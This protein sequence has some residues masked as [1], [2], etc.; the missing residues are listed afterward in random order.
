MSSSETS[1]NWSK[2]STSEKPHDELS[3]SK[4][5]QLADDPNVEINLDTDGNGI[6]ININGTTL[7]ATKNSCNITIGNF[8]ITL[9]DKKKKDISTIADLLNVNV[10]EVI[11]PISYSAVISS[12]TK[13]PLQIVG[14]DDPSITA[15]LSL[16]KPMVNNMA[17]VFYL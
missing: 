12:L 4:E 3:S 16:S 9:K 1:F 2:K 11:L 15:N 8:S 13:K 6:D 7:N 5:A 14:G 17:T 10:R